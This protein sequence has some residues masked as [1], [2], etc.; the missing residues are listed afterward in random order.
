MELTAVCTLLADNLGAVAE[1]F[2][3]YQQ[4]AALAHAVVLGLVVAVAAEVPECPERLALVGGH[5]ALRGIFHHEQIMALCNLVDLVHLAGHARVVHRHN[6]LRLLGNSRLDQVLVQVHRVGAN[7]HEHALGPLRNECVGSTHERERGHNHL[8]A[9]PDV[10]KAGRHLERMRA[11]RG[12]ERLRRAGVLLEP[13]VAQQVVGAVTA[14]TA[15]LDGL[16]HIVKF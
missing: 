1:L 11:A 7:V 13:L 2:I 8:V 6:R 10:A 4:C 5:H 3:V 15:A 14:N 9:R 12:K 16:L